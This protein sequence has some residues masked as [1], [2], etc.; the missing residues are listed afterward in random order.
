M[1]S[2]RSTLVAVGGLISTISSIIED[3]EVAADP[4]I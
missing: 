1:F 3:I 4:I 2:A